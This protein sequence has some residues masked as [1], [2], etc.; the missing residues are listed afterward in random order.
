VGVV[1]PPKNNTEISQKK[2]RK[3]KKRIRV[4]T[5][6]PE[7]KAVLMIPKNETEM[8]TKKKKQY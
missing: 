1:E 5:Q 4:Y 7:K 2:E 8:K 3:N 6:N